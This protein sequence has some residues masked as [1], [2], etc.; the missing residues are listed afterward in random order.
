M[1]SPSPHGSNSMGT[2]V[3]GLKLNCHFERG[4]DLEDC[5]CCTS[6]VLAAECPGVGRLLKDFVTY[7]NALPKPDRNLRTKAGAKT[8][9]LQTIARLISTHL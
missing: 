4:F 6:V 1:A 9:Q 8:M 7:P 2:L 5:D 3:G